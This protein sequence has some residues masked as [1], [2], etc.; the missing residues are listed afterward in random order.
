MASNSSHI[1]N[2][3]IN[4]SINAASSRAS[5]LG[6][7]SELRQNIL[8][9]LFSQSFVA[10]DL[11]R[12]S[13]RM[14]NAQL[15]TSILRVCT[16]LHREGQR[17]LA[18][19][20]TIYLHDPHYVPGWPKN[21]AAAKIYLPWVRTMS[22]S[23]DEIFDSYFDARILPCLTLLEVH[24]NY[25]VTT[26]P[27]CVMVNEAE[28]RSILKGDSDKD[29]LIKDW[30]TW[31][32]ETRRYRVETYCWDGRAAPWLFDLIDKK[33]T[34]PFKVIVHCRTENSCYVCDAQKPAEKK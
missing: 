7:P 26:I 14:I 9:R 20:T 16:S 5:F 24:E 6:I 11:Q 10:L 8:E 12:S 13:E 23:F 25:E 18:S 4:P 33:T 2:A 31:A 27:G 30:H 15:E 17:L 34:V 22:L 32:W 28:M 29:T 3:P 19:A 21:A 1:T